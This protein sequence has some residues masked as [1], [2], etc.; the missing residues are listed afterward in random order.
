MKRNND[1]G[2]L[3]VEAIIALTAFLFFM[4]FMANFGHIYRA[5]NFMVHSLAQSGQMLAFSSYEYDFED[6][7]DSYVINTVT[8]LIDEF[9]L[10]GGPADGIEMKNAWNGSYFIAKPNYSTAA[11]YAFKYCAGGTKEATKALM[12]K[13]GIESLDFA[14]TNLVDDDIC[15]NATYKVKL[16][17]AFFGIE[18]AE[19]HQQIACRIWEGK[20]GY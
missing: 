13:Y 7:K 14:G 19:M 17:F 8:T 6:I 4:M 18:S 15:I 2:S 12:E 9:L 1:E 3:T 11:E 16:P 20:R 5:Q 10:L